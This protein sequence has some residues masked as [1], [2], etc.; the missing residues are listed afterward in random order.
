MACLLSTWNALIG[1]LFVWYIHPIAYQGWSRTE[2]VF[3]LIWLSV[4]GMALLFLL[5]SWLTRRINAEA[6]GRAF[7]T[8]FVAAMV[9]GVVALGSAS[10]GVVLIFFLLAVD[11]PTV[12]FF[13]RAW[14]GP[15]RRSV[16]RQ[17]VLLSLIL[18]T[19]T[20]SVWSLANIEIVTRAAERTADGRPYCLQVP[21]T[22]LGGYAPVTGA[23]QLAGLRMQT[24]VSNGGGSTDYQFAFHAVLV[25]ENGRIPLLFNWSYRAQAFLPVSDRTRRGMAMYRNCTPQT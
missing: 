5:D 15:L 17:L 2:L 10:Y 20:L 18:P 22:S 6:I 19:L 9:A 16:P 13:A 4:V 23:W 11:L 1:L 14:P 3:G 12:T 24:P 7:F 25:V 8:H 21:A